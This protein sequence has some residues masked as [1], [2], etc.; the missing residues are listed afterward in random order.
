MSINRYN[1]KRDANEPEIVD[2]L[3]SR[4]LSVERLNTPLDLLVGYNKRNYLVEVKMPKKHMN[5]KQVKFTESWKGQF[6]VINS[7]E[8]AAMFANGVK[9]LTIGD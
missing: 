9:Q 1:P 5:D 4:G 2:Y 7:I 3:K 8:Q 6:I